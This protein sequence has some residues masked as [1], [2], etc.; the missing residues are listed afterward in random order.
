MLDDLVTLMFTRVPKQGREREWEYAIAKMGR[1]ARD[2]PGHMG[3]TVL[4]PRPGVREAYQI[5]VRFDS[6]DNF[7]RWESSVDRERLLQ[8]LESL[9]SESVTYGQGTGLETWFELPEDTGNRHAMI[10]PPRHK[11]MVVSGIGVYLTITPLLLFL[12]PQLKGLPLYVLTLIMVTIMSVLLTY[13]VMP[14]MTKI[15]RRWLYKHRY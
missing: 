13:I 1:A 6:L 12:G 8:E 15:F 7:R 2:F 3:T 11:M 5:I 4:K 14:F 9:E 10:P